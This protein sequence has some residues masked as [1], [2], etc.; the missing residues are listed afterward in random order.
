M[1]TLL[2]GLERRLEHLPS[3][4]DTRKADALLA[5]NAASILDIKAG[6]AAFP[7]APSAS[8]TPFP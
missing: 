4:E 6:C 3:K 7:K 8:R 1:G 2:C 5:V